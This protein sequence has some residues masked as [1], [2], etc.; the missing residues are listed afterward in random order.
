M[1]LT[2]FNNTSLY[3]KL[4]W[5]A[6]GYKPGTEAAGRSGTSTINVFLNHQRIAGE[7]MA[8]AAE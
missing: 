6:I 1:V 4:Y 8:A 2:A 7:A 5:S 3:R